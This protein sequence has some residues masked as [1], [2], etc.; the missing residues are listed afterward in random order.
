MKKSLVLSLVLSTVLTLAAQASDGV[1]QTFTCSIPKGDKVEKILVQITGSE[2]K[3]G[4]ALLLLVE[5]NADGMDPVILERSE[6]AQATFGWTRAVNAQGKTIDVINSAEISLGRS[7]SISMGTTEAYDKYQQ[8]AGRVQISTLQM[9]Y[10]EGVDATCE[11]RT[12]TPRPGVSGS[13]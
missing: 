1:L 13:N 5:E 3:S 2:V 9:N 8:A 12:S 7:G 11:W 4:T 10:P 6:N